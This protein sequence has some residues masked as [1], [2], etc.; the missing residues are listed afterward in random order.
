MKLFVWMM[1]TMVSTPPPDCRGNLEYKILD[2]RG[3]ASI[4]DISRGGLI[5]P[6]GGLIL[7]GG[8]G[9]GAIQFSSAHNL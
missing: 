1:K 3:W 6:G 4:P 8:G 9:G 5:L 7:P 2:F